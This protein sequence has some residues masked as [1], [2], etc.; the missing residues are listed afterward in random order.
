MKLEE[1]KRFEEECEKEW[2]NDNL[3]EMANIHKN[4]HGI[5][6]I[7]IWIGKENKQHGLRVKVSN[8][9]NKF[10]ERNNF[11][12]KMPSLDYNPRHVANWITSRHIKAIFSWIKLN[13]KLLVDYEKGVIDD[14]LEF[15]KKIS[16]V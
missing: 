5:D 9:K 6:D 1:I 3:F 10:D 8:K 2:I 14:T 15:L 12:I 4:V 16:S 11:N 7:V 13:Q